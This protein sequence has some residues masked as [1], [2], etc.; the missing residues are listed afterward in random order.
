M[1]VWNSWVWL[2]MNDPICSRCLVGYGQMGR[3]GSCYSTKPK[4]V[5]IHRASSPVLSSPGVLPVISSAQCKN[6]QHYTMRSHLVILTKFSNLHFTQYDIKSVTA[7]GN[8]VCIQM[9]SIQLPLKQ[10]V[11][12]SNRSTESDLN[13]LLL[14]R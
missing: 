2:E 12:L 9:F 5:L 13:T 8:I 6:H 7:E 1:Y 11:P 14:A 3:R 10:Y 4:V